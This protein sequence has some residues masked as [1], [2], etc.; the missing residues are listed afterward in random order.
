MIRIALTSSVTIPL[1]SIDVP[2]T[3]IG[4]GGR[5]VRALFTK[6]LGASGVTENDV[7][8]CSTME[9][10]PTSLFQRRDKFHDLHRISFG[11][12]SVDC[13]DLTL[14]IEHTAMIPKDGIGRTARVS[15]C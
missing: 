4:I 8:A 5:P 15:V 11:Y 10:F 6:Y 13:N 9:M 2:I 3:A 14:T 12:R 1:T 7:G